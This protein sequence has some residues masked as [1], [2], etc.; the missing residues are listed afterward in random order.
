MLA[1]TSSLL[2]CQRDPDRITTMV[3]KAIIAP[4]VLASDFGQ[5]AFECKRITKDGAEWLHMDVMDGHFVPNMTIGPPV[6]KSVSEHGDFFFDVHM[7]VADPLKWV[8]D[9]AESGGK[10]YTFHIE[11]TGIEG[12]PKVIEAIHAAGM[13]CGVA[14]SPPTPS[15]EITDEIGEAVDMLLVMTVHPGRG[16]QKFME[17]CVPKVKELRARFPHKDIQVD[18]GVGPKTIKPCAEAGSNVIVS[19]TAVFGAASPK[20][21]MDQ[22]RAAVEEARSVLDSFTS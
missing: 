21:A 5:L 19:G 13:R 18:G 7:M 11:A 17:E 20:E 8:K 4:S 6:L 10:S 14:I 3:L 22:M 12:A 1:T 9:V 16:G 15:T 2:Y